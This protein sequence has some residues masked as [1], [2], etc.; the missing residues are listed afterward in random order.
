M[1][2][3]KW[4][5]PVL[6]A[7]V[8]GIAYHNCLN[9]EMFWDDDD[10]ILKNRYIKDWQYFP[11]FFSENL[12][13]GGYLLSNYWRPVLLTVF[14]WAWHMWNTWLPGWHSLPVI[15]HALD[16]ILIYFLFSRLF[17]NKVLAVAVGLIFVA[18][19]VHNEAVVYVN[20]LGDSLATFFV[21][22][23]LLLFARFRQGGKPSVTS[24]NFWFSLLCYPMAIMSKETGFVAV[25]LLPL[26][27]ILLLQKDKSFWLRVRKSLATLW[28]FFSVAVIYVIMRGTCLNF[29]GSFNFYKENNEFTSSIIVR[30]MTFFKAMTQYAGFLFFPHDLRVERQMP[31]GRSLLEWDVALGGLIVAAMVFCIFKFWRSRPWLSFGCAWFFIAIAPASNVLVPINAVL[32][33]HFLYMPMIGIVLIVLKMGTVTE[34][35]KGTPYLIPHRTHHGELSMVSPY[36]LKLV[37]VPIFILT[38]ILAI[39]CA[40]NI[41][42]N[43]DWHTAIGFYEKLVTYAP[44][45]RVINNLGMEYADKD[46][47]DKAELWYNKAIAMDPKNP[48]AYHNI[49]GIYRDSGRVGLAEQNFKKAI[50]LDPKFIFSYSSLADLYLRTNHLDAA[51]PYIQV[52]VQFDPENQLYRETY[53]QVK[54]QLGN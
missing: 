8:A 35:N 34:V 22:S 15:F 4:L 46:I 12:V 32:Y 43:T 21:L 17:N 47:T 49:A 31:W 7:L 3:K 44:S 2:D 50:E 10:F 38:L 25:G 30:L 45:Y 53:E 40:I 1:R 41:R 36:L 20:S 6:I 48:V 26:M 23:C 5:A 13:A 24:R 9:N 52:L 37:T 14:A 42:R 54:K 16:G 29:N 18:H 19:P 39:F 27:D 28:P 51:L 11:R 33:E